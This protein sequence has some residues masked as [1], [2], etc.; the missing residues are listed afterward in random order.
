[1]HTIRIR[2][3][4]RIIDVGAGYVGELDAEDGMHIDFR[5]QLN[6]AECLRLIQFAS[7]RLGLATT[8]DH[9]DHHLASGRPGMRD[10]YAPRDMSLVRAEAEAKILR[11]QEA[12]RAAVHAENDRR[13]TA[14]DGSINRWFRRFGRA[15]AGGV[16]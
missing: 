12:E 5:P 1:M 13:R 11:A 3:T 6:K 15:P 10:G 8:L 7:D 9:E 14:N 4:A 16:S 2:A